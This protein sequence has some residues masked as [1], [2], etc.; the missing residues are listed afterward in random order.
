MVVS[1]LWI[2]SKIALHFLHCSSFHP[3]LNSFYSKFDYY[4]LL[5][6]F[7]GIQRV[8][9]RKLRQLDELG[10]DPYNAHLFGFS[11]GAHLVFEGAYQ[12]G[13]R[14]IMRADGCDP[15]AI[16]DASSVTHAIDAAQNVQCIHTSADIGT[17]SRYCQ[18]DV[19]MGNCG[20]SQPAA[21]LPTASHF[22]CPVLYNSAFQ[23]KFKVVTKAAVYAATYYTCASTKA[24]DISSLEMMPMYMGYNMDMTAPDGEYFSL[25]RV[26]VPFNV[27]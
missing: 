15:A 9:T 6:N 26:A 27:L 20:L 4:T 10:F 17:T 24:V 7:F 11:F 25:T 22:M 8:L 23:N 3:P 14:K 1:S 2:T 19:S 16:S 13:P 12:Y 18:K 5:I 21:L